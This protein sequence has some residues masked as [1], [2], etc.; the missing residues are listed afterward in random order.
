MDNDSTKIMEVYKSQLVNDKPYDTRFDKPKLPKVKSDIG[1]FKT[2]VS[3]FMVDARRFVEYKNQGLTTTS[4]VN[5]LNQ[6]LSMIS[7]LLDKMSAP[8]PTTPAMESVKTD[9]AVLTE[10]THKCDK[11]NKPMGKHHNEEKAKKG[12]KYCQNCD[13]TYSPEATT[14][15]DGKGISAPSI[16]KD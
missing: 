16:K 12:Y 1:N 6:S 13:R 8:A 7:N 10:G 15:V 3:L 2:A 11:C 4:T 5:D 14:K 9:D